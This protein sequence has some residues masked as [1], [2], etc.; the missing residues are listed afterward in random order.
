MA[1]A[2]VN[3]AAFCGTGNNE[4]LAELQNLGLLTYAIILSYPMVT[5][6]S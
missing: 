2:G 3:M 1:L 5:E 6:N 4:V